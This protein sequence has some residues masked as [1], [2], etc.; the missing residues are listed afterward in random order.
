MSNSN[1]YYIAPHRFL[2]MC[3]FIKCEIHQLIHSLNITTHGEGAIVRAEATGR[4]PTAGKYSQK[5]MKR[6]IA[7]V[8]LAA[9]TH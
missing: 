2:P 1:V 5:Q 9:E 8:L 3:L 6:N 7:T 4:G